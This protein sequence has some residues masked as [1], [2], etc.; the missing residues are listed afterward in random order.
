MSNAPCISA[1][2][3]AYPLPAVLKTDA[4]M[5]EWLIGSHTSI[6]TA[7]IAMRILLI[8]NKNP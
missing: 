3:A 4:N 5:M 2:I 6:P 7:L 8:P 1:P